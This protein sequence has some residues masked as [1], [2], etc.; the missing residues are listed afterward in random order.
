MDKTKPEINPA[1]EKTVFQLNMKLRKTWRAVSKYRAT[2][3][4]NKLFNNENKMSQFSITANKI[5][6]STTSF[7]RLMGKT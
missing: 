4:T 1:P 5:Q 2:S 3:V 6:L 7:I